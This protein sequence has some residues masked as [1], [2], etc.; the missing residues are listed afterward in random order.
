MHEYNIQLGIFCESKKIKNFYID[1]LSNI[2]GQEVNIQGFSLEEG[3][4]SP[5]FFIPVV[6]ASHIHLLERA[7][8]F[9]PNSTIIYGKKAL[10]GYNLE[11]VILLPKGKKVLMVNNTLIAVEDTIK[12]LI[13]LGLDHLKYIP[14]FKREDVD[15]TGVDTAISPGL[16]YLCPEHIENKIDIGFRMF[17]VETFLDI[18]LALNLNLKYLNIYVNRYNNLLMNTSRRLAEIL[19]KSEIQRM[20][21][22][23]IISQVNEGIMAINEH[24]STMLINPALKKMMAWPDDQV[25]SSAA[26]FLRELR[27]RDQSFTMAD[28]IDDR[29]IHYNGKDLVYSKTPY[30]GANTTHYILTIKDVSKLQRLEKKVRQELHVK[31]HVAK[32]NFSDIWG[33]TPKI[34]AAKDKAMMFAKNENTILIIGES[35]TGKELFAHAIHNNSL[36]KDGPFLAVN[37]AAIP[38]T[39]VESEL[40]GYEG[41]AF[42]GARKEGKAGM[43]ELAHGGT[44]F[45]D[46]I[47]D[48]PLSIQ[49]RL[50]RVLQEKEIMRLGGMKVIPIDVRV[51]AATNRELRIYSQE[52]K[53]RLDLFYRLNV[54]SL[55]TPP[56]R[57]LKEDFSDYLNHYFAKKYNTKKI[58]SREVMAILLKYDWPGNMRELANVADYFYFASGDRP[59]IRPDDI[60]DY[61]RQEVL[62]LN[63]ADMSDLAYKIQDREQA[64]QLYNILRILADHKMEKIGRNRMNAILSKK[65]LHYSEH[66]LKNGLTLLN[67]LGLIETGRTKQGSR[68]TAKGEEYLSCQERR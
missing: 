10:D 57:E 32:Y 62:T 59:E 49:A 48:A 28:Q 27:I 36:I 39:L 4:E 23:T 34:I 52:G 58:V 67:S 51:I 25:E 22:E 50:L 43:F 42:T 19:A 38:E 33:R 8:I 1:T 18:L 20:E 6:L 47:G 68:I 13:D 2:I 63:Q 31:G 56:L 11:K 24:G 65:D 55:E 29:L 17:S 35:G 12:N 64:M 15:L 44:I 46:E 37:F 3:F 41:G 53:F 45:L 66:T 40:F 7:E 30:P 26:E 14:Y 54:L 61:I 21:Q 60:P 5:D 9:F 16:L